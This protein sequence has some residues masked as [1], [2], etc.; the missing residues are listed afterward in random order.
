MA[1]VLA[2]LNGVSSTADLPPPNAAEAHPMGSVAAAPFIV[3]NAFIRVQVD[4]DK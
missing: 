4:A 1:K 3:D 2:L